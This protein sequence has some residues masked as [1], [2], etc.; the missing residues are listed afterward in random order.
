VAVLSP[1]DFSQVFVVQTNASDMGVGGTLT[2][3]QD[4]TETV[5]AY[6]SKK[7]TSCQ[8]RYAAIAREL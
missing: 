2:Q 3:V 5:I 8:S 7:L 6:F 4:G 1:P